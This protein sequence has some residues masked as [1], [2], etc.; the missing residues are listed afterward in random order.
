MK[1]VIIDGKNFS[2]RDGFYDEV[3]KVLTDVRD[4]E[5]GHNT[6]AL[7]DILYGGFGVIEPP[8]HIR[9]IWR[10]FSKSKKDL[11]YKATVARLREALNECHPANIEIYKERL[12]NAEKNIGPTLLDDIVEIF[13]YEE[14]NNYID[15]VT[16]E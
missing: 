6:M 15:F 7:Q 13:N 11:G 14:Y 16:K 4:W 12:A 1:T 2:T 3:Q 8:E 10:N 5:I 9:I